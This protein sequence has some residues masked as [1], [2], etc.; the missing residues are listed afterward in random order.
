[1]KNHKS[2]RKKNTVTFTRAILLL[3]LL[4][5]IYYLLPQLSAFKH[6]FTVIWHAS[7]L[8]LLLCLLVTCLSFLASAIT[9][10]AAGNYLGKLS[11][12]AYLDFAGSFISHFLPFSVGGVN[13]TTRY[14]RKLGEPRPKA[15]VMS[16]IPIIFGVISTILM[17]AIIS[18]ITLVKYFNKVHNTHLSSWKLYLTIG[19][20]VALVIVVIFFHQKVKTFLREAWSGLRGIKNL[21]QLGVLLAGSLS[22]TFTST[23]ILFLSVIA[24]HRSVSLIAIFVLYVTSSLVSNGAPTPGG[25]GAT[26]AVLVVGLHAMHLSLPDAAAVTLIYRFFTFWMPILPGGIALHRVN[27]LKIV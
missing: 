27:K 23:A 14:Y 3:V 2:L 20:V 6:T 5:G 16:T 4:V 13:L 12:I 15:I 8:W 21:K 9:Q 19:I 11:D 25:I 26:E 22:V 24:I 7:W 10:F 18:P 1:M 17:V